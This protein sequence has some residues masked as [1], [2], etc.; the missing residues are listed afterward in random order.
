MAGEP[1]DMI[2]ALMFSTGLLIFL[3]KDRVIG[4]ALLMGVGL[5]FK[6]WVAIF[7]GGFLLF[8]L[9]ERQWTKLPLAGVSFLVPFACLN[10]IDGF[11]SLTAL[12]WSA[13]HQS[14]Y[15]AWK[16]IGRRLLT[17]GML[18]AVLVAGWTTARA[19]NRSNRLCFF[20]PIPY[21]A[22]VLINRD[23]WAASAVMMLCMVY[24]GFLI[25]HFLLQSAMLGTGAVRR[26]V[27]TGVLAVYL[28]TS[29]GLALYDARGSTA[30]LRAGVGP[31]IKEIPGDSR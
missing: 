6:F 7:F 14:G 28:V 10:L 29:V 31:G 22:Y 23:A 5:L 25:G 1:D 19:P 9:S 24:F 3:Q 27:V 4:A 8:L 17:T 21:F 30:P 2:A 26:R 15:T 13:D 16:F 11:A 20:V 12:L 18:P